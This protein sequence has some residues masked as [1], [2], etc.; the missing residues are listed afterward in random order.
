M[1]QKKY[2]AVEQFLIFIGIGVAIAYAVCFEY[3][4]SR[5]LTVWSYDLLDVLFR[6]EILNFYEYILLV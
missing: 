1:I 2:N 5:T 3:T 4:D 6:G